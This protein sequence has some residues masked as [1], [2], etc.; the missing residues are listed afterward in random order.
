MSK[1]NARESSRDKLIHFLK[2]PGY[3]SI[4]MLGNSGTGKEYIL[5]GIIDSDISLKKLTLTIKYPFE[6]G[7]TED[8][9]DKLFESNII[10]IK[11]IEELSEIQQHILHKA[12]STSDGKIGL[13]N[14]GLKR[15]IFTSS[16]N[17][18]QLRDSKEFLSDRFWYRISQLIIKIPSLDSSGILTDFESV[19]DKMS[20][21]K[22]E[23]L[24]Q[25]G[26]FQYW[27]KEKCG[28]FAG[29]FR[30]LDTIAILWHQYR[31]IEYGVLKEPFKSDFEA[32]I[33]RKVRSDF[34]NYTHYPTQKTDNTNIVEFKKGQSWK[35]IDRNFKSKFKLWAKK[36]YGTILNA[37]KTLNMPSRKMDKW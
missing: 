15:I 13:K 22:F 9:I 17:V 25:D 28:K 32:K 6:I 30:D 14:K 18:E 21:D 7:E 35:D 26:D 27:L 34:E 1:L 33:F 31:I 4:L 2:N 19:W 29:N 16:F 11:N 12:L 10:V 23:E 37:T 3:F 36:E 5:K 8:E 24:P 20:F